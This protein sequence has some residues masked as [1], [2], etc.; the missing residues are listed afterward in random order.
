MMGTYDQ[1]GVYDQPGWL[2]D[3]FLLTYV[4]PSLLAGSGTL[5][6]VGSALTAGLLYGSGVLGTAGRV[7]VPF[8][9]DPDLVYTVEQVFYVTQD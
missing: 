9:P 7:I 4:S 8:R 2:Y 6:T 1:P 3:R 5:G